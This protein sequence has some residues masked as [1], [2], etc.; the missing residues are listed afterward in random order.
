MKAFHHHQYRTKKLND[1]FISIF[2][3]WLILAVFVA[4][5]KIEVKF[6]IQLLSNSEE[7]AAIILDNITLIFIKVAT[8]YMIWVDCLL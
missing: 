6:G 8:Y 1:T 5:Y 3:R 7:V 2:C 4:L